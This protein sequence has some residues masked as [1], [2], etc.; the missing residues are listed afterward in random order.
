MARA[1]LVLVECGSFNPITYLHLRMMEM[2][3]DWANRNGFFVVGGYLSP[4]TDAYKKKGLLEARHR[5]AMC[6]AAVASS[7]WIAVDPWES[8]QPEF[9]RTKKTLERFSSLV[10]SQE[11]RDHIG[12]QQRVQVML[13]CGADLVGSFNIPD[14]WSVKDM[15][16]LVTDGIIV[17]E[18]EGQDIDALVGAN[19]AIRHLR[20]QLKV[21]AQDIVNNVSSTK[22]RQFFREGRSVKYLTSDRV[23]EYAQANKLYLE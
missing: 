20:P 10:N 8:R 6:E 2:A 5:V 9:I 16:D 3:K 15:Q 17:I 7:D 11:G 1:P 21:V 18:R 23:I 19:D 4:V 12:A 22:V 14:L 13:V